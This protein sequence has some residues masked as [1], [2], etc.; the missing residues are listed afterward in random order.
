MI[1]L[2]SLSSNLINWFIISINNLTQNPVLIYFSFR[3]RCHQGW[4]IYR[5]GFQFHLFFL[6]SFF[7][8]VSPLTFFF[9]YYLSPST[10]HFLPRWKKKPYNFYFISFLF[11]SFRVVSLLFFSLS[12]SSATCFPSFVSFIACVIICTLA[13]PGLSQTPYPYQHRTQMCFS[14]I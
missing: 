6:L 8:V 11:F 10:S 9:Y 14:S 13:L 3:G 2:P 7:R 4:I 5:W 1:L 12:L